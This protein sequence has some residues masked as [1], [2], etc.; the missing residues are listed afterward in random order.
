MPRSKKNKKNKKHR[1]R[2][3]EEPDPEETVGQQE[4]TD[5]KDDDGDVD[6]GD[7]DSDFH[8]S[9]DEG[10]RDRPRRHKK[11]PL[12]HWAAD[13]IQT[14]V[15]KRYDEIKKEF[16]SETPDFPKLEAWFKDAN[17]K[18]EKGN[19]VNGVPGE[20]NLIPVTKYRTEFDT[21]TALINS[22]MVNENPEKGWQSYDGLYNTLSLVNREYGLPSDWNVSPDVP[23]ELFGERPES[24]EKP[25]EMDTDSA[26][27]FSDESESEES[28][29]ESDGIDALESRMRKE[30]SAL[31]RGKVLYW[32]PVGTGTQIFVRYGSKR[33]P[34][35]R[36]RAGSSEPYDQKTTE[37]VLSQTRGNS[38]STLS[39][40]GINQEVWKYSRNQVLDI[41]GVGWKVEDDD[42]ANRNA[43]ALIRPE[44]Y[45]TYP[46][47]RALVKWKDGNITLERRAFVRRIA[48]GNSFNGDRMIYLK[49]KELEDAY[50]GYDVEEYWDQDPNSDDGMSSGKSR[51]PHHHTSSSGKHFT[52]SRRDVRFTKSDQ[53]SDAD[54][55]TSQSSVDKNQRM[56]KSKRLTSTRKSK[57]SKKDADLDAQIRLLM[58][59]LKR[60]QV[61][62]QRSGNQTSAHNRRWKNRG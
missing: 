39:I 19:L 11:P 17:K 4:P 3:P 30:Y 2:T 47:T 21:W 25:S 42:E 36:V 31:S 57:H 44:R 52:K 8:K 35:Y 7:L 18:I 15:K 34:I 61:K 58:E 46:H 40:N 60:L 12:D 37:L 29:D 22:D 51:R 33:T 41:I 27:S 49:A 1:A 6:M 23:K 45:A 38:K 43:L 50:W 32:W 28:S 5:T 9:D 14:L 10:P 62:Q 56:R 16:Q 55:E 20:S 26:V 24:V 13:I 53:E 59:E 48:N 54:S